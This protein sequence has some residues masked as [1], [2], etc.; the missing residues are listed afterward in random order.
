MNDELLFLLSLVWTDIILFMMKY[1]VMI[2]FFLSFWKFAV[3]AH[4]ELRHFSMQTEIHDTW[5]NY[6]WFRPCYC[7]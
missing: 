1:D 3:L 5:G 2:L 7:E 4:A 6:P